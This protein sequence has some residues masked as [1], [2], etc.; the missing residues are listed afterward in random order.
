MKKIVNFLLGLFLL[1]ACGTEASFKTIDSNE[2]MELIN[3][4]A[5]IIDVRTSEEVATGYINEAINIELDNIDDID[6]DKSTVII[7]YCATG[8]RS[9]QA[10]ETLI[11]MG[12][13][14]VYNLDGG[15]L[16]WGFELV[17]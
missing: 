14:N 9:A 15:I 3:N 4:G 16:N 6:F 12:Y 10:A 1:T 11:D 13:E 2:A 17:E 8:I 7:V 5:T